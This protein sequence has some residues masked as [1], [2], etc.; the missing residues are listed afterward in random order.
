MYLGSLVGEVLVLVASRNEKL[1]LD[2][3]VCRD[4]PFPALSRSLVAGRWSGLVA[5]VSRA[6]QSRAA[7]RKG[8]AMGAVPPPP[9]R[10]PPLELIA[11]LINRVPPPPSTG[12]A[13]ACCYRPRALSLEGK[14]PEATIDKRYVS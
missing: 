2:K 13:C 4:H 12:M 8:R 11:R 7:L 1:H 9:H 14:P 3:T 10:P 6:A 5:P